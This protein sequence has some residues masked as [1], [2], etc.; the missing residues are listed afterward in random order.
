[1]GGESPTAVLYDFQGNELALQ[2]G[3]AIPASTPLLM[4]GGSDG[5]NSRYIT[6]DTS[7]RQVMVGIGTAGTPVGGVVTIQGISGGTVVPISGTVTANA[8]TGNFAVVQATAANLN[9][10]VVASGNFNN[11]SVSA[12]A[13]APPASAT[14]MGG[15]VTTSSPTYTTGQMDPLSLTTAGALRIDGSA[16][17]Q[18]VSGTV[19]ANAGT[20][21][22]TVA[23]TVT[24][25]QGTANTL[26]NAWSTKITD[27]TNGPA[28]VKPASTAAIATDPALVVAISPNNSL[29]LSTQD[30]TATG[31]LGALNAVV[32]VTHPG[33]GSVGFQLAAGTLIGT[34]VTEVSFDGGA[35]WNATFFDNPTTD[36]KVASIV[37]GTSN[38]AT[39]MTI[40]G[41]GGA[42]QTR[43]RVS[44]YTS[45]TANAT[46]RASDINDPS[47]LAG[48]QAGAALPPAILQTGG[49][50]T[51]AAPTYTTS[52]FNALSLTTA[53]SLRVASISES[54]T[55]AAGPASA[56]YVAGAV[57]TAAPTYTTG[58]MDPLSLTTAGA[59]RIDGS[60]V[61]QPVSGTITANIGTTNGLALD[62]S[63]NGI[64]VGQASTTAGEKGPLVQGAVTTAAPAY[65]TGQTDPISLT[66][67]GLLRIDGVYP[68]NATTPTTDAVFMA[69]AV[70]TAAP[71]YTTGQMSA[72]SLTTAGALRTDAS[73]TTQPVSGTV[74][75][76]QGT[77][78]TLVNAWSTKITDATNGPVAVKPASTAALT[79]DPAL[80]VAISPNSN[81]VATTGTV[82]VTATGALGALNAAVQIILAG[83]TTVGFQLAAGT[84]IGTIIAEISFDGGTT[85]TATYMDIGNKVSTIVFGSANTATSATI[86]GEGGAGLARVRVSAYTSGTA[87]I[88]IRTSV[89]NDPS[90]L[91]A[92]PANTTIQPPTASQIAGWDGTT[93]RVPAVKAPSTAA[94]ATDQAMV[95]GINPSSN[96]VTVGPVTVSQADTTATGA[97]GALNAAVSVTLAGTLGSAMQ[98]VAGTLVGTIVPEVSVDGG[99]TWVAAYFDDPTTGNK[100]TNIVFGSANTATTRSIAGTSGSSTAR[101]RVSAYTSGTATC[102]LRAST[103][104]DPTAFF[105]GAAGATLPPTIAQTGGSVTTGAPTYTTGTLNALSLTTG[106]ALRTDA[107]ATTQP[108]Q[109]A[110]VTATGA[111]GA[112]NANVQIT[113]AGHTSTGF[114]LAAGTLIGTILAETSFDG[115]TTWT[116]TYMDTGNKVTTIV[117][118]SANTATAA[119]VVGVGGS[120]LVRI[121]V[122]AYTSGTANITI[123]SSVINDPSVVYAGLTNATIQPPTAAQIAGWDGT[124]LRVPAVKA[125]ST[126]AVAADQALVVSMSPNSIVNPDVTA[127][128]ALGALNAAVQ[129]NCSGLQTIG[130]QLAAGTLAGTI[131]P[132]FSWD[133]G[134]TWSPGYF[135]GPASLGAVATLT[136]TNPNAAQGKMIAVIGG[137]GLVRVRVSAYTSGTANVT[138]RASEVI[139]EF[140]GLAGAQAGAVNPPMVLQVGG[141]D[142]T[143]LRALS[144]TNTGVLNVNEADQ[145]SNN[146]YPAPLNAIVGTS[147]PTIDAFG[148]LETRGPILTDEGSLRDDFTGAALTTALTG[149][150]TF[151]NGS[152]TVTGAGTAF[153]TQVAVGQYIKKSADPEADYVQ[154]SFITSDTALTLVSNYVG[155][156]G[157][158]AS[159]VSN[160]QTVTPATGGSFA[161][162]ASVVTLACGTAA[163]GTGSLR[164]LGDYLPYSIQFYAEVSQRIINQT[165]YMGVQDVV[166]IT[167][168]QQATVQFTGTT[169]T[170]VNFVTCFA[171][172]AA[173]TQTTAVTLP[174]A[175]T[176][177]TYHLYKID[178]SS[179]QATLSIDGIVVAT[180]TVH[181][182]SP[183]TDLFIT[184]GVVNGGTAPAS[185]TNLLIDYV[186]FENVDRIQ[187][188]NDFAGEAMPV[189]A[190]VKPLYGTNGQA[191]TITLA[192]LASA[193]ARAS[194]AIDN[195]TNLYEDVYLF[196]KMATNAA[197][198]S[199]TGYINVYGYATVDN[200]TTYPEA[201]TGT[202]AGVTLTAPPNLV[203]I[204]QIN[205]NTNGVTKTYGPISFCRTYGFD[206][207][208]AKWGVV[209]VNQTGA[210]FTATA[211][212]YAVTYQGVNGQL[213]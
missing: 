93:L 211:G 44:A 161:V 204:A 10:T 126:A 155:T 67:A 138:I 198:T 189:H 179:N 88:T 124:T 35:T 201:I 75:A 206:R 73:A 181:L 5:T 133:G 95:V 48:G 177:A 46:V 128:G 114:Q 63:V 180:N 149:T 164:S 157:G 50:V 70:T 169:N 84:L 74:T 151:T 52:T 165:I 213:V 45:G 19:T 112:L 178:L 64:L 29:S 127:T 16:V 38:T 176:T 78:N 25:N 136:F 119:T 18:P 207:L 210:A 91:H 115:G 71:T 34:L 102:N 160:W 172:T 68:I 87:N 82:D 28:A 40:V 118:G 146:S 30:V 194:T 31:A 167:P 83:H 4:I 77:A 8:G 33:L 41:V 145:L 196:F 120:G 69:G 159:V 135:I 193:G 85:W 57:T 107:S 130:I 109:V 12:T 185:N 101:I 105:D 36:N 111:L 117:F 162:S 202:D 66:T 184:A 56:T 132:E 98:L 49:S 168:N 6:L 134:T 123:R 2:N 203:L 122:S 158:A 205:A 47:L 20:G 103:Q 173:D 156:T 54:A 59:L 144:T 27:A 89:V 22:F 106:G 166:G 86:V 104:D 142:G 80:V 121:R 62:S 183:Y 7:G 81:A 199:T 58:Q 32:T 191:M 153:T 72:L 11:A 110:D 76:N 175:G 60:A 24:A 3:V 200:G 15:S 97:L 42:G 195:T 139:A 140:V 53:G 116:S 186:F 94:V 150:V 100:S 90:T 148:N 65:T 96:A 55:G 108:I 190:I 129:V 143:D 21:T 26:A 170:T 17:T 188:D 187:I 163:N 99:T 209:V 113:L 125:A 1:M 137:A 92:A 154:V 79:T 197:G 61:T 131:L 39:A 43:V 152:T 171:N 212:N 174:N 13:A 37:F 182:P 51:T 23:G 208:P 14:Y 9:A 192:S 141:T 147:N